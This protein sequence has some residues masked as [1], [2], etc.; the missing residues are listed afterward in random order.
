MKN[1]L[2]LLL[3]LT[4]M[5]PLRVAL[6][7][8]D[9]ES[10]TGIYVEFYQPPTGNN[11]GCSPASSGDGWFPVPGFP[12]RGATCPCRTPENGLPYGSSVSFSADTGRIYRV[13]AV[14]S[15]QAIGNITVFGSGYTLIVG[16]PAGT[17]PPFVDAARELPTPGGSAIGAV[18]A[19]G[20]TVQ[21]RS[22]GSVASV[23]AGTIVRVDATNF[24][25]NVT[26]GSTIGTIQA[27]SIGQVTAQGAITNVLVT[28]WDGGNSPQDYTSIITAGANITTVRVTGARMQGS[29]YADSGNITTVDASTGIGPASGTSTS[30][31]RA[32]NG[33]NTITGASVNASIDARYNGGSG[34]IQTFQASTG[35]FAG[36]LQAA[37]IGSSG[38][39]FSVAGSLLANV[40]ISGDVQ[41]PF[42]V[43]GA[44]SSAVNLL[45]T[46]SQPIAFN[47]G[48]PSGTLSLGT[49]SNNVTVTGNLGASTTMTLLS[50]GTQF[51]IA[52]SLTGDMTL[53]ANSLAGQ[54]LI[55]TGNGTPQWTGAITVGSTTLT[56]PSATD[57]SYVASPTSLGGGTVGLVPYHLYNI[58]C[59]PAQTSPNDWDTTIPTTPSLRLLNSRFSQWST[60]PV[61]D[62]KSVKMRFYGPIGSRAAS[63]VSVWIWLHHSFWQDVTSMCNVT[64]SGREVE[65]RGNGT[66]LLPSGYYAVLAPATDSDPNRL[67]CVG[68]SAATNAEPAVFANSSNSLG[69]PVVQFNFY[70]LRDCNT[71]NL[72]DT[73]PVECGPQ[74][75][76]D[77]DDGSGTGHRD[78]GVTIDDLLFY[79]NLFEAGDIHADVDNGSFL[80]IIDNGITVDDLLYYLNHFENGC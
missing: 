72:L 70:L 14:G 16:R 3:T 45:G 13:F 34:Q 44:A 80:G 58:D 2:T 62:R 50:S 63:P 61:A 17:S 6:A 9:P 75:V 57:G 30:V 1:L 47:G 49:V 73:G 27:P 36:S 79:I 76:A 15:S 66:N 59:L 31:I 67:F 32:R 43:T 55:N 11:C 74:C 48:F 35:N 54:V 22:Y 10:L 69:Q 37:G 33:I 60:I 4:L 24:V 7:Q 28:N 19:S 68:T 23:N 21:V 53:P 46:L 51:K 52:G 64:V 71:D 42:T 26:S 41:R 39:G 12:H 5:V 20:G 29:I 40:T 77:Y 78:G 65:I 38:T 8:E 56:H 25:G 18:D